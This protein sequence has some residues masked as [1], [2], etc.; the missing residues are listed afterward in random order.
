[1]IVHQCSKQVVRQRD[2]GEITR[3][4]QVDVF[5][6]DDLRI[7][8]AR[9]ASLDAEDRAKRRLPKAYQGPSAYQVERVAKPDSG[10]GLSLTGGRGGN[11]GDQNQLPVRPRRD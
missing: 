11:G 5:H 9:R 7:A 8:A 10:R 4:M 1:M 6:W 3:E 2:S